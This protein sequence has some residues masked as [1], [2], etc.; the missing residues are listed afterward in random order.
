MDLPN[1]TYVRVTSGSVLILGVWLLQDQQ[2]FYHDQDDK[3]HKFCSMKEFRSLGETCAVKVP[4]G[5]M[6]GYL[7]PAPVRKAKYSCNIDTFT[8]NKTAPLKSHREVCVLTHDKK[9][10]II[11]MSKAFSKNRMA[12]RKH[13]KLS[14]RYKKDVKTSIMANKLIESSMRHPLHD[15]LPTGWSTKCYTRKS[16]KDAGKAYWTYVCPEGKIYRSKKT[17]L[18]AYDER[19]IILLNPRK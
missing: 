1:K 17:A 14:K 7:E 13:Q 12:F 8:A 9:K 2:V 18:A 15:W 3:A 5:K 10:E 16:G 11:S 6:V 4:G 19:E